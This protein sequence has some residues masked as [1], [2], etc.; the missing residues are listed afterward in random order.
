[1]P[2]QL[3]KPPDFHTFKHRSGKN[4]LIS[5]RTIFYNSTLLSVA[6]LQQEVAAE[7]GGART[8]WNYIT[9]TIYSQPFSASL[10]AAF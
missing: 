5:A 9:I 10:Q 3:P 2:E 6:D 8:I 7:D 4:P 1:M